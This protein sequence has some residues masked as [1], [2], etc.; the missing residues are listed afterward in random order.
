[1]QKVQIRQQHWQLSV[2]KKRTGFVF[3]FTSNIFVV[4]DPFCVFVKTTF[5]TFQFCGHAPYDSPVLKDMS[6]DVVRITSVRDPATQ[7]MSAFHFY[8]ANAKNGTTIDEILNLQLVK[9]GMTFVKVH[10]KYLAKKEE[11]NTFIRQN[12][13]KFFQ[14]VLVKEYLDESL[15]FLRRKLC[16]DIEDILYCSLKV[17]TKKRN[18]SEQD[19]GRIRSKMVSESDFAIL[20]YLVTLHSHSQLLKNRQMHFEF[21]MFFSFDLLFAETMFCLSCMS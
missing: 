12:L 21:C 13:D 3:Q 15:V 19:A 18:L 11:T 10:P 6:P 7:V 20:D 8:Y 9:T 2:C 5:F 16:W 14:L 17:S 4:A 1:M